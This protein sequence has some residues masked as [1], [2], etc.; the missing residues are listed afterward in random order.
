M[1]K[2]LTFPSKT[3]K[4]IFA[5]VIDTEHAFLQKTAAEYHPKIAEYIRNAKPIT[6]KTQI[7][8]TALGAGEYW[9]CFLEGTLIRLQ[10][11]K[12]I[13]IENTEH[14]D[15]VVTHTNKY[16]KV[17]E[18]MARYY[19]GLVHKLK[20]RGWGHDLVSTSEH[21]IYSVKKSV[22]EESRKSY[23]KKTSSYEQYVGQL[24]YNFAQ[25]S[26]ISIGDYIAVPFDNETDPV[27]STDAAYAFL[28]GT[29]LAE[30]NLVKKYDRPGQ[31]YKKIVFTLGSQE[32]WKALKIKE[33]F[34][35]LGSAARITENYQ[36]TNAIRVEVENSKFAEDCHN[37]LGHGAR[38]KFISPAVMRMPRDWQAI[39]LESYIDG[40]GCQVKKEGRYY[41][42][43]TSSTAS[44]VLAMDLSKLA[45]RLGFKS[46]MASYE[47]HFT[48]LGSGNPIFETTY[49]KDI[50]SIF[51]DKSRFEKVSSEASNY[52]MIL[53]RERG[54]ILFPVKSI[55][56]EDYEGTVYNLHVEGDNSYT[57]NGFAV[58][59]CNVNG[60]YF[61][62]AALA[63]E[64]SEYGHKTF[65]LNAKI[66][67]HHVNKDPAAS[68][69]DVALSVYNP[70]YRRVELIVILDNEKAPDIA[71]RMADGDYPEWS[72]GCLRA[73]ELILM[74][75]LTYKKVSE[76]A[77]GD[78]VLS[79]TGKDVEVD[80]PHNHFHKGAWLTVS[81]LGQEDLTT[82]EEHPWLVLDKSSLECVGNKNNK[83]RKQ[84]FC[85][86]KGKGVKKGCVGC[87][88]T[89]ELKTA[90]KK[91]EELQL[92]DYV[93][94]P[95]LKGLSEA[96]SDRMAYLAGLYCAEGHITQDGYVSLSLNISEY[97]LFDKVAGLFSDKSVTC[98]EIPERNALNV[99][100]WCKET[101]KE[102]S[103]LV[104]NY[105]HKKSLAREVM[106]WPTSSQKIFMGAV[107]DGDGGNY[108][109]ALYISTCNK[110]LAVQFSQILLRLGC[111][112]SINTN[113]H[114]PSTIV[115]KET[116]EY[117]VWVGQDSSVNLEGFSFKSKDIIPPKIYNNQRFII[118]DYLWSPITG[119]TSDVCEEMVYNIAIKSGSYDD[120]SYQCKNFA[121]HNCRV[122]YD[123]CSICGN[124]APTTKHYCEHLKY[125]MG[126]IHP[127]TGR[128]AYAINYQPKFFDISQVLIGAD[129][130]AKTLLKVASAQKQ[131]PASAVAAEKMAETKTSTIEKQVP[132]N[133]PPG[134]QDDIQALVRAIPEVK[135]REPMLP[136]EVLDGMATKYDIPSIMSTL[137]LL[138]II[139]KPQ[140]FQRIILVRAGK[141]DVADDL[142]RKN[143][144]FDPC[145]CQD[146]SPEHEKI[147]GLSS[148]RFNPDIMNMVSGYVPS[149]SY[150]APHL[151]RRITIIEKTAMD[152]SNLK[153]PLLID[154]NNK[155]VDA[156]TNLGILPILLL[157][158]G[159]YAKMSEKSPAL[160][161]TGVG[162][163]VAKHPG[164]AAALMASAPMLFNAVM[165]ESRKGQ[166]VEG[167]EPEFEIMKKAEELRERAITKTAS[168]NI[169]AGLGRV[170][171]GVPAVYMASGIL[172]KSKNYNPHKEE[173]KITRFIRRNPDIIGGA[174]ALDGLMAMSGKGSHGLIKKLTK[175]ADVFDNVM[176][177]AVWPLAMGSKGLPARM[178]GGVIDQAILEGSKKVLSKNKTRDKI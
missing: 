172:Q 41:G 83:F 102:L 98:R 20:F 99:G 152:E 135:A 101:A 122:P 159:L 147:L 162:K 27:L 50:T 13:A 17:L 93:A 38:N 110:N 61:P 128:V 104:G 140:E 177:A 18:P 150:A 21:P 77:T 59:N 69:G 125:Y 42:T 166:F 11:G 53:D 175:V 22:V 36:D 68:F 10:N 156:R 26:E 4:G 163:V 123:V 15:T 121:L 120:D 76:I 96:P 138:G 60:D 9:G 127:Q 108:H 157:A 141:K 3:E 65:E 23:Y 171:L 114:K 103:R 85:S 78:K 48:S 34:G 47:Q 97:H 51:S 158:S 105:S 57:V 144:C 178:L 134:S 112:S 130:T 28:M 129:R 32:G 176:D 149:R 168:G 154:S 153:M 31:P 49:Q 8:L 75:D 1:D 54:Y 5:H 136:R 173:S 84:T 87:D 71:Q 80:Y 2:L 92:G 91:A 52:S 73:D 95:I 74:S 46:S 39:F 33:A 82:T 155:D 142:D 45:A 151:L 139:P 25:M 90:W 169:S 145:M 6:G 115:D 131:Y 109:N 44:R 165:G 164:L 63:Y 66:Y 161:A 58:H 126:R 118:G 72:M 160:A 43:L 19:T 146:P 132:A 86:P 100:I 56:T 67:K 148:D 94:T 89:P 107:I 119:I 170:F 174:M 16:Q 12:E 24:S 37:H 70:N 137:A 81:A 133:Q 62:E 106:L 55:E 64:G 124:K 116:V 117:Q 14:G 88:H 29:Y 7:L 167:M 143:M 79:A 40:D 111:I 113:L 30:G 35:L